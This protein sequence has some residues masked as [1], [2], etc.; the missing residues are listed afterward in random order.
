[1]FELCFDD[2][3]AHLHC[4]GDFPVVVVQFLFQQCKFPDILHPREF[5]VHGIDFPGDQIANVGQAGQAFECRI[6]QIAL[7]SPFPNGFVI[8]LD[9]GG[10]EISPL[11]NQDGLADID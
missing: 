5:L 3:P 9:K 4:R 6:S 8:N 1:M 7:L 11:S 2:R 10:Q